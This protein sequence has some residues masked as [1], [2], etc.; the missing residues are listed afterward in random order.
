MTDDGGGDD[1]HDDGDSDDALQAPSKAAI[2]NIFH[3]VTQCTHC[4]TF[5]VRIVQ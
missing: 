3:C 5:N 1:D 4:A 2:G